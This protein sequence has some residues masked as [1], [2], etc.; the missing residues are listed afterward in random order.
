MHVG[1][2]WHRWNYVRGLRHVRVLRRALARRHALLGPLS[3]WRSVPERRGSQ[4]LSSRVRLGRCLVR[5]SARHLCCG[6]DHRLGRFSRQLVRPD[7]QSSVLASLRWLDG[8]RRLSVGAESLWCVEACLAVSNGTANGE[9]SSTSP[10]TWMR[11]LPSAFV[12]RGWSLVVVK[13]Y[14]SPVSETTRRSTWVPV[15]MD[16]SYA[17]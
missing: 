14:T 8:T 5:G 9:Q 11:F 17:L 2:G 7:R 10:L 13:V 16:N 12:T 1:N 6:G 4:R 15:R 3:H